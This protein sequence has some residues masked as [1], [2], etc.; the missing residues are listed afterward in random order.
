MALPVIG[1][2]A[3]AHG[4]RSYSEPSPYPIEPMHTQQD[5]WRMANPTGH[6]ALR[7]GRV[8]QPGRLY[9]LTTVTADRMPWFGDTDLAR[10]VGRVMIEPNAWGDA[11]P[12]CWVLMPDHWHGLV[13]LGEHDGLALVMN[14][15][16]S[17][18]GKRLHTVMPSA[19]IWAHGY[20]D[21]ALRHDEDIHAVARYII[22]NPL[23]AGLVRRVCDYPYWDCIWL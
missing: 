7:K 19:R 4:V 16:K 18:I 22:A 23:R 5:G 14:R 12:L 6:Q 17:L 21:H 2:E 3:F 9:L 20:H 13:E 8:S 1:A 15:F 10:I 11:R